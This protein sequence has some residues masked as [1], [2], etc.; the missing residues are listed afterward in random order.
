MALSKQVPGIVELCERSKTV[1]SAIQFMREL[2]LIKSHV[3]CDKCNVSM[4][5]VSKDPTWGKDCQVWRC[6]RAPKA[7]EMAQYSR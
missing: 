6:A 7:F 5:V 3:D 1:D 2:G 4:K